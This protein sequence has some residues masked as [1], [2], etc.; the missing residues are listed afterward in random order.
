M[1]KVLM[2]LMGFGLTAM[3][4]A[5]DPEQIVV[6]PLCKATV[7]WNQTGALNAY[8]HLGMGYPCGC[9][10][11]AWGQVVTYHG[12]VTKFPAA[13]WKPTPTTGTVALFDGSGNLINL[14][15][16][17]TLPGEYNWDD[18]VNQGPTVSRLMRD[19]GAL[20]GTAYRPGMTA[21]TFS[22]KNAAA[23]FGYQGVG[24]MYTKP[25]YW[26]GGN[27]VLQADWPDLIERQ[28]CGSLHAGAPM[29]LAIN[30]SNGGHIIIC[31][32]YGYAKDGTRMAHLHY[33]WGAGSGRWVPMSWFGEKT[34]SGDTFLVIYVNV[35]P[36][37][38]GCVLAG[39]VAR[40]GV[41]VAGVTVTLSTGQSTTT[42]AAGAYVFT[43]LSEQTAYT[44]TVVEGG[45]TME[46]RTVTTGRFVDDEARDEAQNKWEEEHGKEEAHH[47]PLEGGNVIADFD[48]PVPN[49]YVTVS[50]IGKGT[51]WEDAASLTASML[52][53]LSAGTKVYVASGD[54]TIAETLTVPAGVTIEGGYAVSGESRDVYGAPSTITLAKAASGMVPSYLFELE[55][56]AAIDGFVMQ[57]E[58]EWSS[59]T[60]QGGNAKNCIF[61]GEGAQGTI[62]QNTTL[63][64][65]IVRNKDAQQEDCKF[66][67]CTFYGDTPVGKENGE[68]VGCWLNAT[69]DFPPAANVG[70]C[71][72]G[73]CP[74]LGLNGRP[75]LKTWGALAPAA[76]G[77]QI[78]VQ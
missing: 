16:R 20:G 61:V 40:G 45:S 75:L 36:N 30:T 29:V 69:Q 35:H 8:I 27:Q 13:G 19:L 52:K 32:G 68:T 53:D 73:E 55:D 10:M 12:R 76:K 42:D 50:G 56:G 60:L 2:M 14:E 47:V 15:T 59:S 38:L 34:S 43:G 1:R 54:Y 46:T 51:S 66:I 9:D 3:V 58:L 57:N 18:A 71:T 44:V 65:C 21:G 17:T 74:E 67:H 64:A 31:D 26:D 28:I 7:A 24:Y 11:L 62:A 41:G 70:K 63:S 25:F 37:E 49:V 4:F 72:C 5:Q 33:G 78:R 6:S 48:L 23:Y 77:F 39:R 22:N